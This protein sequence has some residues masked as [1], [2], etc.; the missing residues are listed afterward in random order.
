MDLRN[1]TMPVK[2]QPTISNS[3]GLSA[4]IFG[5]IV[6]FP[7]LFNSEITLLLPEQNMFSKKLI[8]TSTGW[9]HKSK[10]RIAKI[11]T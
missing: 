5:I 4:F 10:I 11:T 1:Q 9:H 8:D 3:I 6:Y 7:H 2:L